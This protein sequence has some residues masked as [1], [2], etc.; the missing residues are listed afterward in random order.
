MLGA[1]VVSGVIG[2][3]WMRKIINIRI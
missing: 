3:L 2:F 1:A